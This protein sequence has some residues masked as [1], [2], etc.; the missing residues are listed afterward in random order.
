MGIIEWLNTNNGVII[1][2]AT[3]LLVGITGYYA[4]LTRRMLKASNTPEIA[5]SLR[6][7]EAQINC[8]ML[9]IENIGTGIARKI[10]FRTDLSFKTDGGRA[11]GEVAF[12]KNG[13]D[14]LGPGQKIEHFLVSIIGKLDELKKT[15]LEFHVTYSD[16]VTQKG[17]YDHTFRLDFGE[18][19][20]LTTIGKSPLVEIA[21]ATKG[22]QKMK[23]PFVDNNQ[24]LSHEE[25]KALLDALAVL[26]MKF[27]KP[28]TQ[29]LSDYAMSREGI[30]E[31]HPKL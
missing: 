6:P 29:P 23:E 13:I 22:I 3:V 17:K 18:L 24:Q 10:Q 5:V 9:C 30:Y 31:G 19:E 27:T 4:Y 2:V 8:V 28:D 1:A 16:S 20:G 12:L 11:L 26:S 25:F 14:Y 15:P 7:H 21:T